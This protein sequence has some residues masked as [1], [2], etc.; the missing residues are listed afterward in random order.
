M[1]NQITGWPVFTDDFSTI[2]RLV[3]E[4]ALSELDLVFSWRHFKWMYKGIM[5]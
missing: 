2:E 1:K 5:K 4:G 3:K